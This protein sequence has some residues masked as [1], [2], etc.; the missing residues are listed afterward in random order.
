MLAF[1]DKNNSQN[2]ETK[3]SFQLTHAYLFTKKECDLNLNECGYLNGPIQ[4][5]AKHQQVLK[6]IIYTLLI[7]NFG[8]YFFDDWRTAQSTLLPGAS[9]LEITGTYA[10]TFDELGWFGIIF[11]LELETYW[12]EDETKLGA[13]RSRWISASRSAISAFSSAARLPSS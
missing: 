5:F 4:F 13:A 3:G 6:W 11:L 8:Y 12:I 9:F 10:T 1:G 2:Q 7:L